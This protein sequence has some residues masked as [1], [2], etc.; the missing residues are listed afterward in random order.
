MV[1]DSIMTPMRG[2][3]MRRTSWDYSGWCRR[4]SSRKGPDLVSS[5][6]PSTTITPFASGS[7]SRP[8]AWSSL[9]L[10][11]WF[12]LLCYIIRLRVF[13]S[14]LLSFPLFSSVQRS[15]AQRLVTGL[16]ALEQMFKGQSQCICVFTVCVCVRTYDEV[17]RQQLTSAGHLDWS[18]GLVIYGGM[19]DRGIVRRDWK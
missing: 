1:S 13:V 19:N 9:T 3:S 10:A 14:L 15:S 11:A 16:V 18:D 17:G 8:W 4:Y 7:T 12:C 2:W 6:R 5:K